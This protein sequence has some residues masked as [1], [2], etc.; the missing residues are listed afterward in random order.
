MT[1]IFFNSPVVGVKHIIAKKLILK[2]TAFAI[3]SFVVMD[4]DVPV[5]HLRK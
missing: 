4:T 2:Q 3:E 5:T 1:S